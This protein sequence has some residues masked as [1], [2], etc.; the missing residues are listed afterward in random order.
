MHLT[1]ILKNLKTHLIS[2]RNP[3]LQRILHKWCMQLKRPIFFLTDGLKIGPV[4]L[5]ASYTIMALWRF[6][7]YDL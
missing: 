6:H 5:V 3:T 1:C 4:M 2:T 7:S